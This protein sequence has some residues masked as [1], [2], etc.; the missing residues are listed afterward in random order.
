[1]KKNS[2]WVETLNIPKVLPVSQYPVQYYLNLSGL[3]LAH[4]WQP[5]VLQEQREDHRFSA[6]GLLSTELKNAAMWSGIVRLLLG[7][8]SFE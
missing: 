6:S 4:S 8:P 3:H 5:F 2:F 1:M 7:Q